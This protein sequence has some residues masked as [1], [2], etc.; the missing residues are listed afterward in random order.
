MKNKKA[1]A[2]ISVLV[3]ALIFI[4]V[5][6]NQENE[7]EVIE[8]VVNVRVLEIDTSTN[9]EQIKFVGFIQPNELFEATFFSVGTIKNIHV[10][11]NQQVKKNDVLATIDDESAQTNLKN[12]QESYS[13]A[14]ANQRQAKALMDAEAANVQNEKDTI[15]KQR[16]QA[17]NQV[18][19][20][21]AQVEQ[22]KKTLEEVSQD[23]EA[24]SQEV[25]EAETN[26]LALEI[27]L[28]S[29][30]TLLN[31][32]NS[33]D[34]ASISIAQSRYDAALAAY[35]ASTT[36]T[37]IAQ[38]NVVAAQQQVDQTRL[39]SQIEGTVVAIVQS[40]GELATP[41]VPTVVVASNEKVAVF[42]LSQ[43]NVNRVLKDMIATIESDEETFE[44]FVSDVS[45][46]P[47]E[48]SRTYEAKVNVGIKDTLNIGE[49]VSVIINLQETEGIWIDLSILK[50]DGEDYVF[51]V[52][53]NRVSK[54][55]VERLA[56]QNN[57][58][59]V[60]NLEKNDRVIIEGYQR[61]KVGDKVNIIE[62]IYE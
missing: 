30:T 17:S 27:Q 8:S 10:S 49:T 48:V 3:L 59:L 7:E 26:L 23:A 39:L 57:L 56:M 36:Q 32:L 21:T 24:D 53:D 4:V 28:E 51:I 12:A 20:L 19:D 13:V 46:L 38:N 62:D 31:D 29:A 43:S 52:E 11:V 50:N 41:L 42:G 60:S 9:Q 44:G 18:N 58:V 2:S 45:L 54:K 34:P 5:L 55:V 47:D 33:E 1:I 15:A 35:Q 25:L 6:F 22:A 40:E 14:L 61:V 37:T 16:E